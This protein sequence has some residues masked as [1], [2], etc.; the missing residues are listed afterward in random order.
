MSGPV[1]RGLSGGRWPNWAG[2]D[3]A[4]GSIERHMLHMLLRLTLFLGLLAHLGGCGGPSSDVGSAPAGPA[5]GVQTVDTEIAFATQCRAGSCATLQV[6]R[7]QSSHGA[8][9]T[10]LFFSAYDER[11]HAITIP[12]FPSGLTAIASEHF[13]MSQQG[14]KATLNY[15]GVSVTWEANDKGRRKT[16]EGSGAHSG[17]TELGQQINA[18]VNGAVGP[19]V[20][21]PAAGHSLGDYGSAFL[22]LRKTVIRP[23]VK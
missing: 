2:C 20:F 19:I 10:L 5:S 23:R 13:V 11:G 14:T 9:S 17:G 7:S 4:R 12:A 22:T 21:N 16:W 8:A 3:G 6:V 18:D 1:K 15:S